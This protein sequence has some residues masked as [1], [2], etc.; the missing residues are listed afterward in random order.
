MIQSDTKIRI[1]GKYNRKLFNPQKSSTL[2]LDEELR[3]ELKNKYDADSLQA[4]FYALALDAVGR[5]NLKKD[6]F[7]DIEQITLERKKK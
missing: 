5:I 2:Y 3:Q 4:L 1:K 7:V 6:K